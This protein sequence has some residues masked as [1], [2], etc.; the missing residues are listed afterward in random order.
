MVE[1]FKPSSDDVEIAEFH[2]A[3]KRRNVRILMIAAVACLLIGV[4]VLIVAFSASD[5]EGSTVYAVNRVQH[6]FEVRVIAAGIGFIIAGGGLAIKA[7][8]VK[9]GLSA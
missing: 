4:V 7:W 6:K 3:A 5:T 2:A 1:P 8:D 9:R